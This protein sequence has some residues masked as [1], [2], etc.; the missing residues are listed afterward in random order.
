MKFEERILSVRS[1]LLKP[2]GIET[3]QV[4][5]GYRC[6]LSCKHCHVEAGPRRN[7]EMDRGTVETLLE[8]LQQNAI[9]GLDITGGAPELNPHFRFLVEKARTV[10]SHVI[11]RTNLTILSEQ[12]MEDL[13]EF[14]ANNGVEVTASL[15]YYIETNVDRMRGNGTFQKSIKVLQKLNSLGYAD[16]FSGRRLNLV[17]NPPGPLLA[18]PQK[19]LEADYRREM[20]KR[21]GITFDSLYAFNNMPTGRFRDYLVRTNDLKK[22]M[23]KLKNSFNPATLEGLMCR[24]VVNVRWD[25]MLSDCDYNQ[26]L[27]IPVVGAPQHISSFDYSALNKRKIAVGD[28]CYCCTAGQGST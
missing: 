14:Y 17:Y 2:F 21:F 8:V 7:E 12:G 9:G 25:G 1:E 28:H 4:N 11:V 16:G 5:I 22:Y 27:G 13:P 19:T 15:P 18:P 26:M 3:L 24:H 10:V 23:E 20:K 6:N